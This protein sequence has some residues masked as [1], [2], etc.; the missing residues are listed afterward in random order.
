MGRTLTLRKC[1]EHEDCQ[2]QSLNRGPFE[3]TPVTRSV[4]D[5]LRLGPESQRALE[6]TLA[7]QIGSARNLTV[8]L[9]ETTERSRAQTGA[10]ADALQHLPRVLELTERAEAALQRI[11]LLRQGMDA[12]AA[13][14]AT[15]VERVDRMEGRLAA[16]QHDVERAARTAVEARTVAEG[17]ATR[18][19]ER[20]HHANALLDR[21]DDLTT[22]LGRID[23]VLEAVAQFEERIEGVLAGLAKRLGEVER[24]IDL[25]REQRIQDTA[26]HQRQLGE[27]MR[28]VGPS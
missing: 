24:Q 21:G 12:R 14:L 11:D 7:E 5:R 1:G 22:K 8:T 23:A 26:K 3:H 28:H 13:Q 15:S 6:A 2:L 16:R 4:A 17:V 19:T 27:V 9:E 25:E 20:L 10:I 18:L